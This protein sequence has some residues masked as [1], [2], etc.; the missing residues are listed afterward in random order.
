MRPANQNLILQ[1]VMFVCI[2][3]TPGAGLVYSNVK[4]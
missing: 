1:Q 2:E 3:S 4:G